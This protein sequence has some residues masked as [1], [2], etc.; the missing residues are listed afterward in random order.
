VTIQVDTDALSQSARRYQDAASA[1][2]ILHGGLSAALDQVAAA[3]A[4]EHVTAGTASLHTGLTTALRDLA[5]SSD[6][7]ATKVTQAAARYRAADALPGQPSQ[8]PEA[9]APA[10]QPGATAGSTGLLFSPPSSGFVPPATQPLT[11]PPAENSSAPPDKPPPVLQ[12][13]RAVGPLA[14]AMLLL[15]TTSTAKPWQDEINP[16]TGQPYASKEEYAQVKEQGGAGRGGPPAGS[17]N[18][19]QDESPST[20]GDGRRAIPIAPTEPRDP[21]ADTRQGKWPLGSTDLSRMAWRHH[22]SQDGS[23]GQAITSGRNV[24]VFEIKDGDTYRYLTA[25]NLSKESHSEVLL[26]Q[27]MLNDDC[28][29]DRSKV[30]RIYSERVPCPDCSGII[31]TVLYPNAK[32]TW[33][34]DSRED[35]TKRALQD[36]RKRTGAW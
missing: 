32:V 28:A 5:D 12:L 9:P 6:N 1:V 36:Y 33:S 13:L 10:T 4:N 31:N 2:R 27:T 22:L 11:L 15:M 3:A 35:F 23:P 20:G 18:T 21:D 30:T 29:D 7:Y 24:A 25:S 14:A 17:T 16:V 8:A 26:N 34:F 19:C